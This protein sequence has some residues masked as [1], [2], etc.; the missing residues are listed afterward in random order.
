MLKTIGDKI[1]FE[2]SYSKR[3]LLFGNVKINNK[4]KRESSK[5]GGTMKAC[6]IKLSITIFCC[7]NVTS[8]R[9]IHRPNHNKIQ[10]ITTHWVNKKE[11]Y[12]LRSPLL[13]ETAIFKS[14]DIKK[15]QK[16]ILPEDVITI[17]GSN[18]TVLG[19]TLSSLME[20]A[21][22]EILSSA[23][24]F[25][26]FT[27]LKQKDFN[28]K[29][30][31]GFIVLKFKKYPF[32]AKISVE[33]PASLTMP[34]SKGLEPSFTF[35]MSGGASRHFTGFT[36]IENSNELRILINKNSEWQNKY[37][38]P[39]K[40]H[41]LPKKNGWINITGTNMGKQKKITI[42]VPAIYGII[43]EAI[44]ET[45]P[46]DPNDETLRQDILNLTNYLDNK[47]DPNI[48]NFMRDSIT[49]KIAIID[50]E[51]CVVNVGIKEKF[52]IRSYYEW[53]KYLVLK[54][55]KNAFFR[56]KQERKQVQQGIKS[57]LL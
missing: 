41:W 31:T 17:R 37:I 39:Q 54:V 30:K 12:S 26:H 24:T 46:L 21:I 36:R 20:T 55:T 48:R 57:K 29:E 34:Y 28:F 50:T 23:K 40:W 42:T 53:Y 13:E 4:T 6:I 8:C 47:L 10:K 14:F 15:F 18:Q 35:A 2:L 43:C 19:N 16:Y 45:N 56:N 25:E 52:T 7:W 3:S 5:E 44:E 22:Q 1:L 33:N 49:N 38:I 27:I 32:I 9:S 51:N 11:K